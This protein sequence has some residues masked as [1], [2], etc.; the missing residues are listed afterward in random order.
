MEWYFKVYFKLLY[1]YCN[2][3]KGKKKFRGTI[4]QNNIKNITKYKCLPLAALNIF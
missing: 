4:N 2:T 1:V 3:I